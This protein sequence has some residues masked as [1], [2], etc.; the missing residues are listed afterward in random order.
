MFLFC[1]DLTKTIV[2]LTPDERQDP[3]VSFAL[4]IS[5][6]CIVNNYKMFFKLYKEAPRMTG[7]LLDLFVPRIRKT[8]ITSMIK[9]YVFIGKI[10]YS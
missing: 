9:A 1:A 4:K 2:E 3:C 10:I 8:A 6:A 5:T 7:Y